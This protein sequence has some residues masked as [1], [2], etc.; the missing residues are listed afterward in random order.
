M[1]VSGL[2]VGIFFDNTLNHQPTNMLY[3]YK[4]GGKGVTR[5]DRKYSPEAVR[6]FEVLL[7]VYLI[8]C[9]GLLGLHHFGICK[10]AVNMASIDNIIFSLPMMALY[11]LIFL[12]ATAGYARGKYMLEEL[13]LS[14]RLK[15]EL[16]LR[17]MGSASIKTKIRAGSQITSA[18]SFAD[19]L[20]NMVSS[21]IS[22]L[23]VVDEQNEVQGVITPTD[24]L[25]YVQKLMKNNEDIK[26]LHEAR[27]SDLQPSEPT[28]IEASDQLQSVT[29]KMIQHQYTKLIVIDNG[30]FSGTVDALD[31][32]AELL[33]NQTV[34]SS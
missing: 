17:T 33:D 21:R 11:L 22:I 4:L 30:K 3:W 9:S 5:V 13:P 25:L 28:L 1:S 6:A 24:L 8:I 19:A 32:L 34:G 23:A 7:V 26:S 29:E 16:H 27:V 12:A 20:N 31:I 2:C 18:D 14:M 10:F 15:Q